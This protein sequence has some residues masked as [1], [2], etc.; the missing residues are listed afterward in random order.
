[1]ETL[2]DKLTFLWQYYFCIVVEDII[3]VP[4]H[5]LMHQRYFYKYVHKLHHTYS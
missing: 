3:F 5:W 1:M 2:P 4:I